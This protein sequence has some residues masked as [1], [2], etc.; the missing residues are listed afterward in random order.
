MVNAT[1]NAQLSFALQLSVDVLRHTYLTFLVSQGTRLNDL[2][3]SAGY[4]MPTELALYRQV[5]RHGK[6]VEPDA[7]NAIFPF[8][9]DT[10][11][12]YNKCNTTEVMTRLGVPRCP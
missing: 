12:T 2:E 3:Q 5:N 6:G 11:S 8:R 1:D 7:V 10:A 9:A 4:T